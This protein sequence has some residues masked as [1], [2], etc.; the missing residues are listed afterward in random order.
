MYGSGTTTGLTALPATGLMLG[1]TWIF[2]AGLTVL[3]IGLALMRMVP[4]KES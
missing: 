4:R 3:L 2:L 1:S